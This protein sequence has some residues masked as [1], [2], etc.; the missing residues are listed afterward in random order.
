[1]SK[2]VNG[3]NKYRVRKGDLKEKKF[4]VQLITNSCYQCLL[5]RKIC[6]TECE[7]IIE[8]NSILNVTVNK[9]SSCSFYKVT[10][11]CR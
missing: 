2:G 3:N 1:M 6:N 4:F 10:K 7:L 11:I 8:S 5:F 9:N